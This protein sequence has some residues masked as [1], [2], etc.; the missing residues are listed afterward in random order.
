M[1]EN[2]FDLRIIYNFDVISASLFGK[3]CN[4]LRLIHANSSFKFGHCVSFNFGI[5]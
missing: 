4:L 3:F 1:L 2:I 5:I